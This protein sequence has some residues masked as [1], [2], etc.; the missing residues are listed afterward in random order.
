MG[1]V[2]ISSSEIVCWEPYSVKSVK[3]C[4]VVS[5]TTPYD[6]LIFIVL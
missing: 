6:S 4:V 1:L 3:K 5:S 2:H